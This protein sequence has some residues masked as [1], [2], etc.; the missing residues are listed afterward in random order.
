MFAQLR[1]LLHITRSHLIARR[2]FVVNG[3]DGALTLSHNTFVSYHDY[4]AD[5]SV[6]VVMP[7]TITVPLWADD[8]GVPYDAKEFIVTGFRKKGLD[9]GALLDRLY[10]RNTKSVPLALASSPKDGYIV[11]DGSYAKYFEFG[12]GGCL[13]FLAHKRRTCFGGM[14]R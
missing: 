9:A 8:P 12:G 10:E 7:E 3:F 4:N 14:H 2:Y 1:V 13:Q 5:G 11:D 6:N